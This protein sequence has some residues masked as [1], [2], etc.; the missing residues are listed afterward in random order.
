MRVGSAVDTKE[1]DKYCDQFLDEYW[2][3][4]D[5][6]RQKTGRLHKRNQGRQNLSPG[7]YYLAVSVWIKNSAGLYLISKRAAGPGKVYPHFWE[8]TSGAALAGDDS[9][10][11]A[12]REVKEELGLNLDPAKGRLMYQHKLTNMFRDVWLFNHEAD[13]TEIV[14]QEGETC[15]ARWA[16]TEEILDMVK[17]N[18]FVP[19][20]D[21]AEQ[22][23]KDAVL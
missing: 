8:N 22:L 6:N 20:M 11:A 3:I 14:L 9:Q 13:I 2:D 7:E 18:T 4:Y 23:F 21:Y 5:E 1:C 17:N 19:V 12:L 10:T 16:T 15:D